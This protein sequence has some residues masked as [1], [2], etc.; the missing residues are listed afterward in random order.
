M[1]KADSIIKIGQFIKPHGIKGEI[2][3]TLDYDLE[4]E[5]LKCIIT[6]I[7]SIFVP[8][9]IESVRPKSSETIIIKIDS[10]DSD[11]AAKKICGKDYYALKDDVEIAS[12][13]DEY[14]GFIS[15][16]IGFALKDTS[17]ST[18]GEITGYDDSTENVLF[19]VSLP[20]G[21]TIFVPVADDLIVQINP[22]S[23]FMVMQLPEGL[24]DL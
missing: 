8:F 22:E 15:D 5:A 19:K 4:L 16:F 23:H 21:K 20:D 18:I 12:T 6:D 2:T 17:D 9:F 1:I 24:L 7:E 14:G 10:I 3:A 11:T 13:L